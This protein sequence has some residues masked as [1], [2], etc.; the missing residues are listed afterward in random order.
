MFLSSS[1]KGSSDKMIDLATSDSSTLQTDIMEKPR[2]G[3]SHLRKGIKRKYKAHEAMA[4]EQDVFPNLIN[5]DTFNE[6]EKDTP[7]YKTSRH[8]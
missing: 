3:A 4:F 6:A 5:D 8:K 7:Y 1:S 2:G